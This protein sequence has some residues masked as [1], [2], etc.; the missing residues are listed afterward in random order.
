MIIRIGQLSLFAVIMLFFLQGEAASKGK[1]L[2][3]TQENV[4]KGEWRGEA[5]VEKGKS[6]GETWKWHLIFGKGDLTEVGGTVINAVSKVKI[7]KFSLTRP[8]EMKIVYIVGGELTFDIAMKVELD[9]TCTRL[10]G[11]FANIMGSGTFELVKGKCSPP[12]DKMK[13]MWSGTVK[14]VKGVLARKSVPI[15]LE[16]PDGKLKT[17][18][19]TFGDYQE[20]KLTPSVW[21]PK[22]RKAIFFLTFK[23][24]GKKKETV[25]EMKVDFSDDYGSF[26]GTFKSKKFGSGDVTLE[27]ADATKSIKETE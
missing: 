26:T 17:S 16:A 5:K 1:E 12:P 19:V 6:A 23:E 13:G 21:E 20:I 18:Q 22:N 24:K 8:F 3:L 27:K 25:I 4:L 9:Q 15:T 10:T 7:K 11:T 2:K 14:G